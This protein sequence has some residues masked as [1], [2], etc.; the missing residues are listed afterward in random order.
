MAKKEKHTKSKDAIILIIAKCFNRDVLTPEEIDLASDITFLTLINDYCLNDLQSQTVCAWISHQEK[1]HA[2]NIESNQEKIN[3]IFSWIKNKLKKGKTSKDINPNVILKKLKVITDSHENHPIFYSDQTNNYLITVIG[4]TNWWMD[5]LKSFIEQYYKAS[6]DT[7]RNKIFALDKEMSPYYSDKKGVPSSAG[8][9]YKAYYYVKNVLN[10]Y[11]DLLTQL[12][13][14]ID[15]F[16]TASNIYERKDFKYN[17]NVVSKL[18]DA[19]DNFLKDQAVYDYVGEDKLFVEELTNNNFFNLKLEIKEMVKNLGVKQISS[20]KSDKKQMGEHIVTS[21]II[22][23]A[24]ASLLHA[25]SRQIK[26]Y[27]KFFDTEYQTLSSLDQDINFMS[28]SES[29]KKI[30]NHERET[31]IEEFT[32]NKNKYKRN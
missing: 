16:H 21:M 8:D 12:A 24:M 5:Y 29:A 25:K 4:F 23:T 13:R 19:I 22:C 2:A 32:A 20:A 31:A 30:M 28:D 6:T 7:S 26:Q 27:I 18:F 10:N 1:M 15:H 14:V 11:A 17:K 9:S 3:E